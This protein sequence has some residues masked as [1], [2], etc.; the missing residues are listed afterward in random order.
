MMCLISASPDRSKA[1]LARVILDSCSDYSYVRRSILTRAGGV[2]RS[3]GVQRISGIGGRVVTQPLSQS[4]MYLMPVNP[5]PQVHRIEPRVLDRICG[6]LPPLHLSWTD[7]PG[8]RPSDQTEKLPRPASS[9]D[10]LLGLDYLVGLLDGKLTKAGDGNFLVWGTHLGSAVSGRLRPEAGA[11]TAVCHQTTDDGDVSAE[12]LKAPTGNV[13]NE[14]LSQLLRTFWSLQA[15]GITDTTFKALSPDETYVVEHFQRT[16]S[17][18]GERYT[19]ELPF[20]PAMSKPKN[21]FQA[22]LELQLSLERS[23]LRNA[24]K[25]AAYVKAMTDYIDAGHVERVTADADPGGPGRFYLPHHCVVKVGHASH[26]HR[27]VFNGAFPD[28]HGVS[29][30]QTLLPGPPQQPLLSDIVTKF[31]RHPV[32]LAGDISKMFLQLIVAVVQVCQ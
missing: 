19:V 6:D 12:A 10:L 18:D 32:S 15:H 13:N 14:Q 30:N 27:I 26:S 31:R 24:E 22:A 16:I 2:G 11:N 4:L 5:S 21:N 25:C 7:F 28:R 29:L 17:Y 8:T 20:N 9:V 23:L 3:M 1:I